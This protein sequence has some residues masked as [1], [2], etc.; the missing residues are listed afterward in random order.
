MPANRKE[1]G[2]ES[3]KNEYKDKR[4]SFINILCRLQRGILVFGGVMFVIWF[5]ITYG[6]Q[7]YSNS[8]DTVVAMKRTSGERYGGMEDYM[9]KIIKTGRL[10]D[11]VIPRHYNLTLQLFMPPEYNFTTKGKVNILIECLKKTKVSCS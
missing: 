11:H 5:S 2:E 4:T 3:E 9:D 1:F 6:F 7:N 8:G 10:M